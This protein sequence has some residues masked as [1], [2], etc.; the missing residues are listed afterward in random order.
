MEQYHGIPVQGVDEITP[1]TS[2]W[3]VGFGPPVDLRP[4]LMK[5]VRYRVGGA[6]AV[7]RGRKRAYSDEEIADLMCDD[8]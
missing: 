4:S 5:R 7:F 2:I 6:W 1:N 8:W 3:I